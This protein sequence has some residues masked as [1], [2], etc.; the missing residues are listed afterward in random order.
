[1]VI[2]THKTDTFITL[3][4]FLKK[5]EKS[6]GILDIGTEGVS[7]KVSVRGGF[8]SRISAA[9]D[10]FVVQNFDWKTNT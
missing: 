5:C 9:V 7:I 10:L 2:L 1:L 6:K 4:T 3:T 8:Y